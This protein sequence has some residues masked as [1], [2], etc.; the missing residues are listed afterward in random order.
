[1]LYIKPNDNGDGHLIFKLS[2][3]Q[4]LVTMTYQPIHLPEDLIEVINETDSS[5]NKIQVNHFDSNHSLVQDDHSNNNKDDGQTPRN[6]KD[7]SEDESHGELDSS[8]QLIHMKLNNIVDQEN[9]II[10]YMGSSSSTSVSTTELTNT[11]THIQGLFLQYLCGAE[12][13]ILCL[14]HL[15]KRISTNEH[16]ISSLLTSSRCEVIQPSLCVSLQS[17]ILQSF[18][19]AYP[20]SEHLQLSLLISLLGYL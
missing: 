2:T 13:S 20:K 16:L 1:M 4:V 7:N 8:P 17:E 3:N 18:L 14:R 19:L 5:N 6:D 10:L 9:R 12:I 15:Y 11:R